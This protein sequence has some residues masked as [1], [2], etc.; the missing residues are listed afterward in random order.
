MQVLTK[1][2]LGFGYLGLNISTAGGGVAGWAGI[3]MTWFLLRIAP[4]F[5]LTVWTRSVEEV[6]V[7]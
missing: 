7:E 5:A 3:A 4:Y 2:T 6:A 1:A